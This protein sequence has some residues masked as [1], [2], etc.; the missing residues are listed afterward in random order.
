MDSA[1]FSLLPVL[2]VDSRLSRGIGS[3]PAMILRILVSWMVITRILLSSEST[4]AAFST[5]SLW[6][7]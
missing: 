5:A 2:P 4:M 6:V 3:S 7:E 1:V